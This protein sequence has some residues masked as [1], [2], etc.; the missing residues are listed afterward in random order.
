MP[1]EMT[2]LNIEDE[3]LNLCELLDVVKSGWHWLLGAAVV[4]LAA[5][6]GFVIVMPAQYEATAIIQPATVGTISATTRGR[7]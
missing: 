3:G 1:N 7:G 6:F 5:A 4:G 2:P